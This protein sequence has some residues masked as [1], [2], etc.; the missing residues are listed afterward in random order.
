MHRPGRVWLG[1][2]P[3]GRCRELG[4]MDGAFNRLPAQTKR[5]GGP[6]L[7]P[8]RRLHPTKQRVCTVRNLLGS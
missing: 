5:L 2:R 4:S 1:R 7:F 8:S 6:C 3:L